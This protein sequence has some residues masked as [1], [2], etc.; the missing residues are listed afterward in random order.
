MLIWIHWWKILPCSKSS[1]FNTVFELLSL[2]FSCSNKSFQISQYFCQYFIDFSIE[3]CSL[4]HISVKIVDI[5]K[6]T[7]NLLKLLFRSFI[8]F[9]S[10]IKRSRNLSSFSGLSLKFFYQFIV[11]FNHFVNL[12]ENS[13]KDFLFLSLHLGLFEILICFFFVI[14][15]VEE[16]FDFIS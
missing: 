5:I 9:V 13:F 3:T 11:V 4:S 14:N 6:L 15:F 12:T 8:T 2:H 16:L 7:Q 1:F 10:F